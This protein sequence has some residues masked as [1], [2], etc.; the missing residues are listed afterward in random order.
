MT[1]A[2]HAP[3]LALGVTVL[4]LTTRAWRRPALWP[5]TASLALVLDLDSARALGPPRWLDVALY[6]AWYCALALAVGV[7]L[8]PSQARPLALAALA[9]WAVEVWRVLGP[10]GLSGPALDAEWWALWAVG[11]ACQGA[12]VAAW[13]RRGAPRGEGAT[14]ALVIAAGS[15]ADWVG[16][17]LAGAGGAGER[18]E[19][20]RWQSVGTWCC[21]VGASG[22]RW[23][24]ER[25]SAR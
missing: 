19:V 3:R 22:W 9:W 10:P 17:W 14:A 20:G 4:V 2:E 5:L 18:W 21:V 6:A 23:G 24:R 16:P 11:V 7:G 8:A 25:R 12:A 1:L 13:L 15:V